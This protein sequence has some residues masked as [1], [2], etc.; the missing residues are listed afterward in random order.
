M[1]EGSTLMPF[2]RLSINARESRC[3][4]RHAEGGGGG[5]YVRHDSYRADNSV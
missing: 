5:S 4:V 2:V 1:S 3:N